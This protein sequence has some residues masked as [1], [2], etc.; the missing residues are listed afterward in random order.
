MYKKITNKE[1]NNQHLEGKAILAFRAVWCPPCQM[2]G[3]ELERLA[4]EHKD[5]NV[6]DLD[7]DQN[8]EFARE[9]NVQSIPTLFYYVDGKVVDSTMGYLPMDEILTKFK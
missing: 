7:V 3:P 4:S 9:M 8:T 1:L 2:I 5:I 6:F